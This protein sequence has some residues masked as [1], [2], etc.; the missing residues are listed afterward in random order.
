MIILNCILLFDPELNAD[1][2]L[3]YSVFAGNVFSIPC[4]YFIWDLIICIYYINIYGISMLVHSIAGLLVF[5]GSFNPIFMFYITRILILFELSS[6]CLSDTYIKT[7][8]K[9]LY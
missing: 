6:I 9:K 1:K 3:G 5:L 4:G 7:N 8:Q 2:Y